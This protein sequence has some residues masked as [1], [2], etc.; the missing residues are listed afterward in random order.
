MIE[1]FKTGVCHNSIARKLVR[2]IG[3]KFP[4][5]KANFDL[6]DCDHIL[7]VS[8]EREPVLV[9]EIITLLWQA[10]VEAELLP[11]KI[12]LESHEEK[13]EVHLK[14]SGYSFTATYFTAV[15]LHL[16]QISEN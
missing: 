9:N 4:G 10:G 3:E 14:E 12:S 6:E 2:Q 7:R 8:S 1:V 15:C 5:Y 16:R 11:D 13:C